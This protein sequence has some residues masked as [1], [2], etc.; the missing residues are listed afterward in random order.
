[1]SSAI[2]NANNGDTIKLT[3]PITA[4]ANTVAINKLVNLNLNGQTLTGNVTLT[5][6]TAGT[7]NISAGT[8]TGNLTVDAANA[9]VNN[10]ATV[11]GTITIN[12]VSGNTW[13]ENASNNNIV[14]N[15]PNLG[16]NFV[17]GAGQTVSSLTLNTPAV[18][19]VS[20]GATLTTLAV[21]SGAANTTVNNTGTI[22]DITG[23]GLV[24]LA[25]SGE[26]K[27]VTNTGVT[28][29]RAG[30]ADLLLTKQDELSKS[31]RFYG[32][33]FFWSSSNGV[34]TKLVEKSG[35]YNYFNDGAYLDITVKKDGG[36][37][38]AFDTLFEEMTLQTDSGAV[39]IINGTTGRQLADWTGVD[40]GFSTKLKESNS[41][42]VFYG[43]RQTG[44]G[45]AVG[46]TRTVGF[47][48]G[49]RRTINF[50]LT[51]KE[52]IAA[53]TYTVTIQPKQQK[54]V[55]SGSDLGE[56]I[57]YTIVVE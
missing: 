38:V 36:S 13:N 52:N 1:M 16:T 10:A 4:T 14:F 24:T 22:A 44:T 23:T 31:D 29:E 20:A 28:I 43:V 5:S 30:E 37:N 25:G 50:S 41:N 21:E 8:I 19:S 6:A 56:A 39:D 2:T 27:K 49:N 45:T 7:L 47:D 26:V 18:V 40:T 42:A 9:T 17:V 34:G 57:T 3:G 35:R 12:N 15:D 48:A 11:S 53:G 46:A 55:T 33:T 51:T 32:A 54:D